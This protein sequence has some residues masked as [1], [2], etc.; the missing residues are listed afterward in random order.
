MQRIS[1]QI[2]RGLSK[3]ALTT[4]YV[5]LKYIV[6]ALL[7]I[8]TNFGKSYDRLLTHTFLFVVKFVQKNVSKKYIAY[9]TLTIY[10]GFGTLL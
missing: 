9:E 6:R 1:S 5:N 10:V 7:Q 4:Q 8:K 3:R 2:L